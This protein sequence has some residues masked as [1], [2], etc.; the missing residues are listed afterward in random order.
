VTA[1]AVMIGGYRHLLRSVHT[2]GPFG[3]DR[4]FYCRKRPAHGDTVHCTSYGDV[5]CNPCAHAHQAREE[6]GQ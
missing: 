2:V 1:H 6:A 4:C 3:C 5:I